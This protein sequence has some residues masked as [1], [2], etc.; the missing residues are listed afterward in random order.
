MIDL[1]TLEHIMSQKLDD[2]RFAHTQ[3]VKEECE[4][5]AKIFS[6][7]SADTDEL[8]QAALLHDCTKPFKFAEQLMLA[9]MLRIELSDDDMQSPAILH[10]I[11]GAQT[12]K[13]QYGV[14]DSVA[15]AI[16]CHTT[17]KE[18]MTLIEKLLFLADYIE[19]TRTF[20]DCV[21]VR[22]Y[23]YEE[24]AHLTIMERLD[25]TLLMAFD[26]TIEQLISEKHPIHP[27]TVKSRNFLLKKT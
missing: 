16:A 21:R 20:D 17:G 5:L 19:P 11:T 8:L 1:V 24:C 4:R 22:Q 14:S 7:S 10:S 18:D 12:A 9:Q 23:F 26:L 15:N 2:Y 3:S 6:L 25:A 13:V 27:Q